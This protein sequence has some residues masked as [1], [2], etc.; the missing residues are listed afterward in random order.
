MKPQSWLWTCLANYVNYKPLQSIPKHAVEHKALLCLYLDIKRDNMYAPG[1][2]LETVCL[3]LKKAATQSL[4]LEEVGISNAYC[5]AD[6][7]KILIVEQSQNPTGSRFFGNTFGTHVP[8]QDT[9]FWA[10]KAIATIQELLRIRFKKSSN[11]GD[12]YI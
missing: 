9:Y 7:N 6:L 5:R 3:I 4:I 10:G 1:T 2:L 8:L 11:D 12:L